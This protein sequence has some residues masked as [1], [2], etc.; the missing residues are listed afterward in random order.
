[1]HVVRKHYI[2]DA[3]CKDYTTGTL[4][5][6]LTQTLTLTHYF[7]RSHPIACKFHIR[8]LD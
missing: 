8:K 6:T 3:P 5:L 1:V 2:N 7:Y 4:N